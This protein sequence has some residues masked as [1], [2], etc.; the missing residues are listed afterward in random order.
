MASALKYYK[1][2]VKRAKFD[3]D[4]FCEE[5]LRLPNDPWQSEMMNAVADLDRIKAGIPTLYNHEGK[6]RF[7]IC[8]FHGPGKT[9]FMAKLAHWYN[10]TRIGRIPCTA[11]KE[12]QLLTRLWPEFNKIKN[13]SVDEYRTI[14]KVNR[15]SIEWAADMNW[16]MIA[17]SASVPENLAGYHDDNL[18]FLVEEA[19]GVDEQM[20]PAIEGAL[21]TE[22]AILVLIGNPTR[23]EGEFYKSHNHKET[24]KLYYRKKIQHHETSR[25]T[26]EWVNGMIAKYGKNSPAVQV[27]VFG[28]F[29][30][31]SENQLIVMQWLEDARHE[32]KSD[33]SHPVLRISCDVADGGEDETIITVAYQYQTFLVLKKLY[34]FSFPPAKSSIMA[35]EA[36]ERIA[37]SFNY[38]IDN[39]DV[40]IVDGIGVGAGTAGYL[41][42]RNKFKVIVFKAGTTKG[43]NTNIYRNQ[44]VRC[45]SLLRDGF[46]DGNI[47]IDEDFCDTADWEDVVAQL[48][49]IRTKTDTERVEDIVGKK[50]MKSKGI[51]SPDIGDGI[52]ML[53]ANLLPNFEG[54]P[55]V[56]DVIPSVV[57]SQYDAGLV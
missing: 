27:R 54:T 37:E 3:P 55:Q 28:N 10:F 14:M 32:W 26:K 56:I 30:D 4:W 29:V 45:Y 13:K 20:F 16:Q 47:I 24:K 49:S 1:Q 25:I 43:V 18:L 35:A 52:S 38:D 33:G 36:V 41:I 15:T 11:P 22:G 8:A 34:R 7:T 12:K 31:A 46:R 9:H 57:E 19:S 53:L 5:I 21:T 39:G 48:C 17:E 6:H 50:E 40:L 44:K 23:T 2:A 51:K 42:K